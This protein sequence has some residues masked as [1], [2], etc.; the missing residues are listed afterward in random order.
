MSSPIAIELY[1]QNGWTADGTQ[2]VWN[3]SFA[4]GY[5]SK[6]YVKAYTQAAAPGSPQVPVAVT[7]AMFTGPYQLTVTPAVPNGS[8]F[9]IYRE[10][11]R[12][13]PLVDFLDGSQVTEVSLDLVARQAIHVCA[14]IMDG[15]AASLPPTE[16]GF[17]AL[18]RNSYTGVSVVNAADLGKA[19]YKTDGTAVS[20]P[21]TLPVE[22][23]TTVINNSDSAMSVQFATG[24][25]YLQG[26]PTPVSSV[27]L[28]ARSLLSVAKAD[29]ATW[30]ASGPATPI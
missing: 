1:S 21:D 28:G 26:S 2:T 27:S 29:T 9:V 17:K 19:H 3:F 12:D 13:T 10:T 5:I 25:C 15:G 6:E 18:R 16:Y 30:M 4:G 23:L 14:E 11:P 20:V 22:F 24:T 7:E 8:L